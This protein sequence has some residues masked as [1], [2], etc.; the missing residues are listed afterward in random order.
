MFG[1][2]TSNHIQQGGPRHLKP[3]TSRSFPVSLGFG[4]P[5][6]SLPYDSR[7]VRWRCFPRALLLFFKVRPLGTAGSF[8][9]SA[10]GKSL[11]VIRSIR[12]NADGTRVSILSD[13]V[14]GQVTGKTYP[15]EYFSCHPIASVSA[16]CHCRRVFVGNNSSAACCTARVARGT[17]AVISG[18]RNLSG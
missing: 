15:I 17:T 5:F 9:C 18:L 3:H 11:G 13:K 4:Q 10:T 1:G 12:C 8:V 7:H 14:H 16:D 2:W 6:T